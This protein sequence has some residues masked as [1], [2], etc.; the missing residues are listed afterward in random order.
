MHEPNLLQEWECVVTDVSKNTFWATM[1]D[2][3]DMSRPVETA[4]FKRHVAPKSKRNL[5][6]PGTI[7]YFK[8]YDGGIR[9]FFFPERRWT[10]EEIEDIRQQAE[11]LHA[12]VSGK[13]LSSEPE[14]NPDGGMNAKV[15]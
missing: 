10:K 5:I 1:Y 9:S 6:T 3:T 8:I 12:R 13:V 2:L 7:F 11:E 15:P 14:N 4:E